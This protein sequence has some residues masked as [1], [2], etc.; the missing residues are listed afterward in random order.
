MRRTFC[1]TVSTCASPVCRNCSP[2][3]GFGAGSPG[4][5]G[6]GT[7]GRGTPLLLVSSK[8]SGRPPNTRRD[9]QSM[10][11]LTWKRSPVGTVSV[12]GTGSG[13]R[14]WSWI[15]ATVVPN[16]V[17]SVWPRSEMPVIASWSSALRLAP[18]ILPSAPTTMMPSSSVPMNSA[19][20]WKCRR[21]RLL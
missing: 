10:R 2:A 15:A 11:A 3:G 9:D 6:A 20:L 7:A 1:T 5:L 8:P 4:V 16:S 13:A 21:S 12:I 19:R 14:K 17:V 18:R